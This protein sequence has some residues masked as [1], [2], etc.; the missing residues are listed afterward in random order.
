MLKQE[1]YLEEILSLNQF[2]CLLS[3][4]LTYEQVV[5]IPITVGGKLID[6]MSAGDT[7]NYEKIYHP[8]FLV[9]YQRSSTSPDNFP[10]IEQSIIINRGA[11]RL[12]KVKNILSWL[13]EN[14]D[15]QDLKKLLPSWVV[16]YIDDYNAPSILLEGNKA[17][18]IEQLSPIMQFMLECQQEPTYQYSHINNQGEQLSS[19]K[20]DTVTKI[21]KLSKQKPL[22]HIKNLKSFN[23]LTKTQVEYI[24]DFIQK[25]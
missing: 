22:T 24:F 6:L 5:S 18:R 17:L 15:L 8:I 20:I 25:K 3:G 7:Y 14:T 4:Y 13:A 19:F 23:G 10:K 16:E 11:I 9:L 2:V 21:I 12:Y 1:R